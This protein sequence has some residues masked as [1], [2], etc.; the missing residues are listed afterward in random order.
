MI[1]G[2]H[3]RY[4]HLNHLIIIKYHP[5]GLAH[6]NPPIYLTYLD[7]GFDSSPYPSRIQMASRRS[8]GKELPD[9]TRMRNVQH[10]YDYQEI[11]HWLL[12]LIS[13]QGPAFCP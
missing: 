12:F 3:P 2:V 7:F 4:Y 6:A 5:P 9:C 10:Q 1:F 8:W 13:R 11:I